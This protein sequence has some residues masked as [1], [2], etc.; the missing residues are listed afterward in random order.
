MKILCDVMRLLKLPL[1]GRASLLAAGA[2]ICVVS[3]FT[4]LDV[5]FLMSFFAALGIVTLS[6]KIQHA[7]L[8]KT[9]DP[10]LFVRI[11]SAF[12]KSVSQTL[13]ALI[14]ILPISWA[15]FGELSLISPISNLFYTPLASVILLIAP[16]LLI[17]SGI[18]V[19]NRIVSAVLS[20]L[21]FLFTDT[22]SFIASSADFT[23]SLRYDFVGFILL[24]LVIT[25][26]A[27]LILARVY[28]KRKALLVA[29][30]FLISV[31]LF[32]S[33]YATENERMKHFTDVNYLSRGKNDGFAIIADEKS[34]LID[35]SDGSYTFARSLWDA[36]DESHCD[37]ISYYVITHYHQRQISSFARL[38]NDT[39][40]RLLL[41]PEALNESE[42]VIADTLY[43]SAIERDVNVLYYPSKMKTEIVGESLSIRYGG[44]EYLARSSHPTVGFK[45]NLPCGESIAYAGGSFFENVGTYDFARGSDYY[46][47]GSH[48]PIIKEKIDLESLTKGKSSVICADGYV[49]SMIDHLT[50]PVI[51]PN[52]E[53][54][55]HF[56]IKNPSR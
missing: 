18:P 19:I 46:I 28:V 12:Y 31:L 56:Y 42:K 39:Y 26:V 1:N 21:S 48:S 16:I 51:Y 35:V 41:L 9:A 5:G 36:L 14:F 4:L 54:K 6:Y 3:P 37:E 44:R 52:E 30:P 49:S 2:M 8:P 17:A 20:F 55:V 50:T 29:L 43:A 33:F 38:T 24:F 13:S 10:K 45:I 23:L 25:L 22:S 7:I 11:L 34:Y 40:I 27:S 15:L 32:T 53:E 47:F